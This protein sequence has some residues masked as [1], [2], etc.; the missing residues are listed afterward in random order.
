MGILHT[1]IQ[2]ETRDVTWLPNLWLVGR[3]A[4]LRQATGTIVHATVSLGYD[5]N[6]GTI[7]TA[8]LHAAER[9][10]LSKPFVRIEDLGD[11][12]I[13][14]KVGGLLTDVARLLETH[15]QLR[16]A[17]LDL[18]H[19]AGVEIVSPVVETARAFPPS[20]VFVPRSDE[21]SVPEEI[22]AADDVMFDQAVAAA[23]SHDERETLRAEYEALV[24]RR[25][26]T[27]NPA[28]RR[29]LAAEVERL[30]KKLAELEG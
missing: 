8:L 12:S 4:T 14:Y 10:G 17:M 27:V 7:R 2:T 26:R 28:E 24:S 5:I 13:T 9:V 1:M 30:A 15:S 18:L 20:H 16:G 19:E 25:E 6:R 29:R 22:P 21:P 3:P 23:A 11:F